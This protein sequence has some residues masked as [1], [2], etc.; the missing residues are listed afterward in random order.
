[1]EYKLDSAL[2]KSEKQLIKLQLANYEVTLPSGTYNTQYEEAKEHLNQVKQELSDTQKLY[3]RRMKE[4]DEQEKALQEKQTELQRRKKDV[5]HFMQIRMQKQS[6]EKEKSEKTEKQNLEQLNQLADLIDELAGAAALTQILNEREQSYQLYS[7]QI[8]QVYNEL[9]N[10]SFELG[11]DDFHNIQ[12][13]QTAQQYIQNVFL[14]LQ[15]ESKQAFELE[16]QLQKQLDQL[17]IQVQEA[18]KSNNSMQT[19]FDQ[20][21]QQ[22][23]VQ[24]ENERQQKETLEN[25]VNN[26]AARLSGKTVELSEAFTAIETLCSKVNFNP[27]QMQTAE[28]MN[29]W[30]IIG[31]KTNDLEET[32]LQYYEQC[33]KQLTLN[34]C[35]MR[36]LGEQTV[37]KLKQL[38]QLGLWIQDAESLLNLCD[39]EAKK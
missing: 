35:Y 12:L 7:Q 37:S 32:A 38:K 18:Q 26:L 22:V 33:K 13:I 3:E 36:V 16:Q 20:Q 23:A 39:K 10:N 31:E 29:I 30:D 15:L 17:Q 19:V 21:I 28:K 6:E 24:I 27:R 9:T 1:M 2:S 25:E 14:K 8:I 4:M 34:E 5:S 11:H